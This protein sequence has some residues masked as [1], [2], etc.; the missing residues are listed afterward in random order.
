MN[1]G[2]TV[3]VGVFFHR[4]L[5]GHDVSI[6]QCEAWQRRIMRVEIQRPGP[7]AT[8]A[9]NCNCDNLKNN[10]HGSIMFGWTFALHFAR[11]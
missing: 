7:S 9:A 2:A 11:S 1:I 3:R 5:R 6:G 8:L 4:L 10:F